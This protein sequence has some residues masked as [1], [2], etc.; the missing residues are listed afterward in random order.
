ML[1]ARR[2]NDIIAGT[3]E[4]T[5]VEQFRTAPEPVHASREPMSKWA[6]VGWSMSLVGLIL[7]LY[8]QFE[9][10]SPALID[11]Y[12]IAPLWVAHFFRNIECEAG[13][14]FSITGMVLI[15]WPH[16]R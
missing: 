4:M 7:W 9:I 15:S 13:T 11:W 10:G 5:L 6:F 16:L 3:P 12:S 14:V 8:G 1:E 2:A